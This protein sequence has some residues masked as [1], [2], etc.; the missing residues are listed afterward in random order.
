M[1]LVNLTMNGI[2][3]QVPSHYTILEAARELKFQP[4]VF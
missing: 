2:A 1:E 4:Y 3:L